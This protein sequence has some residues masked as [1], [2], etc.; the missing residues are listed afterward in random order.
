[1][2]I[3]NIINVITII[4]SEKKPEKINVICWVCPNSVITLWK[5]ISINPFFFKFLIGRRGTVSELHAV[6]ESGAS[7]FYIKTMLTHVSF[8]FCFVSPCILLCASQFLGGICLSPAW[9]NFCLH[10]VP[11]LKSRRQ[12][13]ENEKQLR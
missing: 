11:Y 4:N 1:M 2:N 7:Q 8:I 13:L 5:I 12:L 3:T 6:K 10:E 9:C